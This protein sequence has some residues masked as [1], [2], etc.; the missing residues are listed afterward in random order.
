MKAMGGMPE[1]QIRKL[2]EQEVNAYLQLLAQ[3]L[4]RVDKSAMYWSLSSK[5]Y[6]RALLYMG[7]EAI[8]K[9]GM[10]RANYIIKRN[11]GESALKASWNVL[12][13]MGLTIGTASAINECVIALLTGNI[14][15]EEDDSV[16]A[17]LVAQYLNAT[18]GNFTDALP[19][20]G[21]F[22]RYALSPYAW[23]GD[24]S[25]KIPGKDA[26]ERVPKLYTMLT[27]DKDYSAAEW[28]KQT[29]G[30]LREFTALLGYGGGAHSTW[31]LYSQ[32]SAFL[33]SLV[34]ALNL[35]YPLT[36]TAANYPELF[37][38]AYAKTDK[39]TLKRKRSKSTIE[40]ILTPTKEKKYKKSK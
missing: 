1:E 33:H 39:R 25:F 31:K 26:M 10:M 36:T 18:I 2:A 22:T 13:R 20:L 3:P 7:S 34:T 19:V 11:N 28:Q 35:A 4:N 12:A 24:D 38:D 37:P 30:F 27:D 29:T 15:D 5:A 17:W 16:A 14:P 32:T 8:N 40:R 23:A 9:V 6:G 21:Q